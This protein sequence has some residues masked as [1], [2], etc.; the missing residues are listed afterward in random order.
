[1][2]ATAG[3][4]TIIITNANV[5]MSIGNNATFLML[6]ILMILCVHERLTRISERFPMTN[7]MNAAVFTTVADCHNRMNVL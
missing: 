2:F 5:I 6:N 4:Y 7:V 1:M 3:T